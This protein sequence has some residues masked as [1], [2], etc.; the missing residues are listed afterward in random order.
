MQGR[1]VRSECLALVLYCGRRIRRGRVVR[2]RDKWVARLACKPCSSEA[3]VASNQCHPTFSCGASQPCLLKVTH[4]TR[5]HPETNENRRS[6]APPS[7]E[8][9]SHVGVRTPRVVPLFA[10]FPWEGQ[11]TTIIPPH[12]PERRGAV[13]PPV[14][15]SPSARLDTSPTEAV[16]SSRSRPSCRRTWPSAGRCQGIRLCAPG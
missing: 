7:A 12:G 1:G 13:S 2:E 16:D 3:L 10:Y 14:H 11:C 6:S 4:G 9:S 5:R 8:R 15:G